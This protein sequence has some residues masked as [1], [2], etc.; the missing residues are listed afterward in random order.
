MARTLTPT[1]HLI[2]DLDLV[3]SL[4]RSWGDI[5]EGSAEQARAILNSGQALQS[6]L[7]SAHEVDVNASRPSPF[8]V[9]GA[10]SYDAD[11][12]DLVVHVEPHLCPDPNETQEV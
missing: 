7:N 5:D 3:R 11:A 2:A 12:D 10:A 8:A 6:L 4:V 9:V 1:G